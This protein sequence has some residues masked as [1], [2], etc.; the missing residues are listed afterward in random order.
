MRGSIHGVLCS[1]LMVLLVI[2]LLLPSTGAAATLSQRDEMRESVVR[3]EVETAQGTR[4]GTGLLINDKRT[5]ATNNHVIENPKNI[6]VT[7]LANGKPTSVPAR[8]IATDPAKDIALIETLNDIYADPVVLADYD[9][10]PPA[11]V[12]AIGYPVAANFVAGGLLPT[13]LLEPSYSVGTIARIVTN[14]GLLGGARLIQHTAVV[15]PGN[16]GGPLFDE[17]GRVIGINTL[18][19][20]PK[21]FDFAQGIFFA[22]DIRELKPML[23]E[24]LIKAVTTSKPCTPGTDAKNELEPGNTKEA[25]AAMFDRFAACVKARPCDRDLCKGRYERRV[26]SELAAPRRD[27]VD[28]R[29]KVSEPQCTEQK[30]AEA[31]AEFQRCSTQQPC[32]FEKVCGPKLEEV[33]AVGSM[34]SRRAAYDRTRTRAVDACKI[35]SAPGVWRGGETEAGIWMAAVTNER[36][37][38]FAVRCDIAGPEP[39]S[40]G[41]VMAG[42][43]KGTRDRW[44]GTR[45]VQMTI[46]SYSEPIRLDL[47]TSDAELSAGAKHSESMSTRGWLKELIGKLSVG[48]V[49]T[50]EEPKVSLDETFSLNGAQEML[51]PCFKAKFVEPQQQQ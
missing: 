41:I 2:V 3:I 38:V 15:N 30:E 28:L 44:T 27:D 14:A 49:V 39:G 31:Y 10:E 37:A 5:I 50:F 4:S 29:M 21:E 13:I 48:S 43:L 40:G 12:T 51:A 25:E 22:V 35:E 33:L 36:G 34:R 16:S 9:T 20:P 1:G 46:D 23:E 17:C 18:R 32:D 7:F 11:K 42:D 19:T 6:W 24:N 45:N 8:L 47:R 26:T